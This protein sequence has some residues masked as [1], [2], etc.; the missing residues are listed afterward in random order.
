MELLAFLSFMDIYL[1]YISD[2]ADCC[3]ESS[4]ITIFT[5]DL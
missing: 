4:V 2:I 1:M 5:F 3:N